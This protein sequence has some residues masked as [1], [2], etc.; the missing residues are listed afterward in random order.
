[1]IDGQASLSAFV[2]AGG[3]SRRF[4]S[5]K[6]MVEISGTP[7]ILR[8]QRRLLQ[9]DLDP[10]WVCDR[11]E[12]LQQFSVKTIVDVQSASGPMSGLAAALRYTLSN[13]GGWLLLLSCDQVL[14]REDWIAALVAGTREPVQYRAIVFRSAQS[15]AAMPALPPLNPVPGL[16]HT[17]LLPQVVQRLEAR[18]F[19]LQ[20][21]LRN[22]QTLELETF[23][24]P[25]RWSFNTPEE[26]QNICERLQLSVGQ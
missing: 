26:L 22:T 9:L 12:R 6:A 18:E 21:L 10:V 16:Y 1:M 15:N 20:K 17:T 11:I 3:H 24:D 19:S 13:R 14:L 2:L 5:D 23:E 25:R 8:L 7:Q 4:G